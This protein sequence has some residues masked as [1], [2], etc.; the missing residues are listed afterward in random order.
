MLTKTAI[1]WVYPHPR[2]RGRAPRKTN[3]VWNE[4]PL[5]SARL[6]PYKGPSPACP[7]RLFR[8]QKAQ[9]A[10]LVEHATENRSVAGSIPALGTIALPTSLKFWSPARKH[11]GVHGRLGQLR[12]T[13]RDS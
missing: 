1:G 3:P 6:P 2:R 10:Q 9:V 11:S 12:Y 5:A 8:R 4:V 13:V 7:A